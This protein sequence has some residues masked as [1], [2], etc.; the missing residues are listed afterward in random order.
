MYDSFR[1]RPRRRRIYFA[2]TTTT[3]TKT[4]AG[5]SA[6]GD[7]VGGILYFVKLRYWYM[8]PRFDGGCEEVQ[9]EGGLIYHVFIGLCHSFIWATTEMR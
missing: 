3:T 5:V 8:K 4:S 2:T 6:G 7:S 1:I 9:A